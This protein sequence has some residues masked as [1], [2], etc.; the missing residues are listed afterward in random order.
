MTSS[1]KTM[2]QGMLLATI[3][4]QMPLC[5]QKQPTIPGVQKYLAA[6]VA[7]SFNSSSERNLP[8]VAGHLTS[9]IDCVANSSQLCAQR[10]GLWSKFTTQMG[11]NTPFSQTGAVSITAAGEA[12]RRPS[13]GLN[14]ERQPYH[15][16][17]R[18]WAPAD[19]HPTAA[20]ATAAEARTTAELEKPSN[21]CNGERRWSPAKVPVSPAPKLRALNGPCKAV[22]PQVLSAGHAAKKA[23]AVVLPRQQSKEARQAENTARIQENTAA[24][25]LCLRAIILQRLY[26]RGSCAPMHCVRT[27]EKWCGKTTRGR[28]TN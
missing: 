10:S 8:Y 27:E 7:F 2:T 26:T 12:R 24:R 19:R 22:E 5:E 21:V 4:C 20:A 18:P 15:L 9:L 3:S 13:L 16:D 23:C 1:S 25:E 17:G 11:G 6:Q 28:A 14:W